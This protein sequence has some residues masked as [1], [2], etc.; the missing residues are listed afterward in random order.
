ML[1]VPRSF[2]RRS[3]V[4][5]RSKIRLRISERRR[6]SLFIPS[7]SRLDEVK[8]EEKERVSS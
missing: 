4:V 6:S 2:G 8:V 1:L 7:E 5:R 3:A